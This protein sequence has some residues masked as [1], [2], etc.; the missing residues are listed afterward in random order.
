MPAYRPLDE[1]NQPTFEEDNDAVWVRKDESAYVSYLEP[2]RFNPTH[3]TF[4]KETV[5]HGAVKDTVSDDF[6]ESAYE[7]VGGIFM[8]NDTL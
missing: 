5:L 2:Q 4:M 1:A 7:Q 3:N 8:L 6:E